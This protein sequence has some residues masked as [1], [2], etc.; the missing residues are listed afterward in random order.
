MTVKDLKA[1]LAKMS[2]DSTVGT[3]ATEGV[4]M[5]ELEDVYEITSA[6]GNV[7]PKDRASAIAGKK[8]VSMA[9]D[10][11]HPDSFYAPL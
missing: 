11:P 6:H 5:F 4:L 3:F 2:D 9:D 10:F 1:K 7:L 8:F